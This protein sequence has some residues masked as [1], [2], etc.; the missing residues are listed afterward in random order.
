[1]MR[2][3]S[4]KYLLFDADGTLFD[5]GRAEREALRRAYLAA[6]LDCAAAA[7]ELYS[8][9]NESLWKEYELGRV[10]KDELKIL[11]FSRLFDQLGQNLDPERFGCDY[12]VQLGRCGYLY[13]GAVEICQYLAQKYELAIITN[14]IASVQHPRFHGSPL[15]GIIPRMYVS[16]EVGF[17]KPQREFFDHVVA[18][19]G[20][21]DRQEALVIGDSLS[22]DIKGGNNAGI[23]TCWYNPAGQSND[24]GI[25]PTFEIAELAT[26]KQLLFS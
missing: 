12:L 11:R 23:D 18:D 3:K 5:F 7:Y 8:E 10:S 24:S 2:N 26:L 13:S 4:Y 16:E 6:G 14:G 25:R 1:M 21:A 17:Q 22:A 9:I 20:I 19:L 15:A